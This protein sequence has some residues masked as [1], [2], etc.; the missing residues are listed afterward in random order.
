M[1]LGV[2]GQKWSK[3]CPWKIGVF[4]TKKGFLL[5]YS[6]F[7]HSVLTLFVGRGQK[8]VK[9]GSKRGQKGWYK[10]GGPG[11]RGRKECFSLRRLDTPDSTYSQRSLGLYDNHV[12]H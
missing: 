7:Q 10:K 11:G 8:G 3:R 12:D 1:F 2:F 9:K 4:D 6:G 5:V